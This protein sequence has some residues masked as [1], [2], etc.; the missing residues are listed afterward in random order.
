MANGILPTLGG[1]LGTLLGGPVGGTI[2]GA[3]GGLL[4]QG[5]DYVEDSAEE[6]E[7]KKKIRRAEAIDQAL[8]LLGGKL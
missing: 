4:E 3:A 2:G 5:I 7:Q 8:E 6:E 1:A